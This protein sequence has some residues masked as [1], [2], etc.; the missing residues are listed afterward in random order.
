M[1]GSEPFP[2]TNAIVGNMKICIV[3]KAAKPFTFVGTGI[4]QAVAG[5]AA[6]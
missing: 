5:T 3:S 2:I 1:F 6:F 4:R